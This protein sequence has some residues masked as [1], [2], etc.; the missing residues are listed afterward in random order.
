MVLVLEYLKYRLQ[1]TLP[2]IQVQYQA[3]NYALVLN[4]YVLHNTGKQSVQ[5]NHVHKNIRSANAY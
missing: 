3:N 2:S 4:S 5:T 1:C